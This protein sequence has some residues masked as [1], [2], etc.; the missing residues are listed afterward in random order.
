[1]L[2]LRIAQPSKHF[3]AILHQETEGM[4]VNLYEKRNKMLKHR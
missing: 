4:I 3:R 2:Q 1:M